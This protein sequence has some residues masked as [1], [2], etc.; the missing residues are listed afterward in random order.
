M[1]RRDF[2]FHST[3]LAAASL[4]PGK[5]AAQSRAA[6]LIS[7]SEAGPNALDTQIP[8]ANRGVAEAS[9]N[10]YDRLMGF[11]SRT[12]SAG[13]ETYDFRKLQ[14]EAAEDADYG[15]MSAT[16][17]L[18]SGA[19]FH[20]GAPVTARDVKWSFDRA[21][22]IGGYP[23]STLAAASI[24]KTEQF[25]VVDDR[26]LRVDYARKDKLTLPYLGVPVVPIY[27]ADAVLAHATPQDPWGLEWTRNNVA[28][29]GAYRLE[30]WTPGQEMVMT[31][32]Q[33]WRGGKLPSIARVIWRVVPSAGTRRALLERGDADLSN[34]L[35]P[36]DAAEMGSLPGLRVINTPMESTVQYLGMNVKTAPF[37]NVKVRQA[38]AYALP[39]RKIM[40]AAIFQRGRL[41]AGGPAQPSGTEW[42]QPHSYDTDP[43]KARALLAEAGYPNGFATTLSFDLGAAVVN[44]PLCVLVAEALG[45][46]GIKVTLDKIPGANW[47]TL[48]SRKQLVL[49]TNVFGAWFSFADF[50]FYQV[51]S[52]ANTIFN[53]MDYQNPAM[54][55]LIDEAHFTADPATYQRDCEAMFKLAFDDVPNIPLF[56]PFLNVAM[57]DNVTGYRYW[58]HRQ[59]DYRC[60]QKA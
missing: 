38:I 41:L 2:L 27:H 14:P 39:Y 44:E 52:G 45:E 53:T 18:R 31:R 30:R 54:D 50:Y 4:L 13:N 42:P 7:L 12:D 56:Q 6:T 29:G 16:F 15:D 33:D 49:Q 51:Y 20:D 9:W 21:L 25:V 32:N 17:R 5:A 48:F 1:I 57:R 26:T 23:Q 40:A 11:G 59:T 24:T 47:R 58:F 37:D 22:S 19:T 35:P 34:D 60:L 8:G 46:V 43:A 36:Q 3:A 10:L 55:R 28:G